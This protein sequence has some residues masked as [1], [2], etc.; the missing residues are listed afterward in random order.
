MEKVKYHN[1]MCED[2]NNC[3]CKEPQ[4]ENCN[5]LKDLFCIKCSNP[6]V[7]QELKKCN[8]QCTSECQHQKDCPCVN[9]HECKDGFIVQEEANKGGECIK[10]CGAK[11]K[12]PYGIKICEAPCPCKCHTPE[13]TREEWN[14]VSTEKIDLFREKSYSKFSSMVD[15]LLQEVIE[16]DRRKMKI[17]NYDE[18]NYDEGVK[19]ERQRIIEEIEK[20]GREFGT[21][22]GLQKLLDSLK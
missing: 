2:H 21:Y 12:N 1:A 16:K 11:S 4:P 9:D 15:T 14:N 20:W 7:A 10:G 22:K 6:I 13:D 8:H 5:H 17:I 18:C 19:F 3:N